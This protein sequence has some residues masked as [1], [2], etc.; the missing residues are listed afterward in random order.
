MRRINSL[1]ICL[2]V[3]IFLMS[4]DSNLKLNQENVEKGIKEFMTNNSFPAHR[5][6]TFDVNSITSI[7][8]VVQYLENEASVNVHYS[9]TFGDTDPVV[10]KFNFKK[11]IENKWVISS[12]KEVDGFGTMGS[13][14]LRNKMNSDWSNLNI[15]VQ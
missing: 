10:V 9:C 6:S 2:W 5:N 14:E 4:C 15:V 12:I 1:I 8:S 3:S 7:D 11:N 13:K